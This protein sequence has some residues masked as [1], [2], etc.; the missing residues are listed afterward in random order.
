MAL[1]HGIRV[2]LTSTGIAG[3]P[4]GAVGTVD[5]SAYAAEPDE[6]E[7]TF[8]YWVRFDGHDEVSFVPEGALEPIG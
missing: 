8:G 3:L 2:L 5:Q 4:E 7:A 1:D 6:D